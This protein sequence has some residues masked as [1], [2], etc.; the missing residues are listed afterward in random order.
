[1]NDFISRQGIIT[2]F[3][4]FL[5]ILTKTDPFYPRVLSSKFISISSVIRNKI[6]LNAVVFRFFQSPFEKRLPW[7]F[8]LK[9]FL[10]H[11]IIPCFIWLKLAVKQLMFRGL[12]NIKRYELLMSHLL[13]LFSVESF[14]FVV[15]NVHGL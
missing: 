2:I 1:M 10:L 8:N 15:T 14:S 7:L 5:Y 3:N 4:L 11:L 12:T 6:F 9:S 13:T